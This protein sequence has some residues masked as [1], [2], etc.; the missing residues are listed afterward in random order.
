[1]GSGKTVAFK[2]QER[3]DLIKGLTSTAGDGA[4]T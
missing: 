2:S 3:G 1:M 4:Q